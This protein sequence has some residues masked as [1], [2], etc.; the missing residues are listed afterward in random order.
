RVLHAV[1]RIGDSALEL[2]EAHRSFQ[3]LPAN[4]HLYVQDADATYRD[5]LTAGATSTLEPYDAP[6]GD[7]ASGVID[8]FGNTWWIHTRIQPEER[9]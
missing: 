6:Y 5:A 1:V 7:R 2:S 3:P 8:P 4:L 9:R